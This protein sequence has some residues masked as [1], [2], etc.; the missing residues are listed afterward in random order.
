MT[1]KDETVTA[2][3]VKKLAANKVYYVRVRTLQAVDGKYYASVWS[4]VKKVKT[5]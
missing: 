1:I 2:Y 4:D 5:K 3:K